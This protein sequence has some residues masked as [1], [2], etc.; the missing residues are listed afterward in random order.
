VLLGLKKRLKIP[1]GSVTIIIEKH[2]FMLTL[3]WDGMYVRQYPVG[4]GRYNKTPEGTF[5]IATMREKPVWYAPDGKVYAFGHPKNV[6]GT[7]WMGLKETPEFSGY[8]IHGTTQPD[9]VGKAMSNGCI[10]MR[11][12]DVEELFS[13]VRIGTK[14]IIRK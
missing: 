7:R 3:L 8:G 1:K 10:R 12:K 13:L 11:N 2:A 4:I 9:S 6:L 5:E 14:V